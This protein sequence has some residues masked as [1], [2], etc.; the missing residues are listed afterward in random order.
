MPDESG[1]SALMDMIKKKSGDSFAA[2]LA[3]A[4]K[5]PDLWMCVHVNMAV[6]SKKTLESEGISRQSLEKIRL[7]CDKVARKMCDLGLAKL[8]GKIF[9]FDD[10]DVAALFLCAPPSGNQ[11][12]EKLRN[13]FIA[14]G[15]GA[16]FHS[17]PVKDKLANLIALSEEKIKSAYDYQSKQHAAD[18]VEGIVTI[19]GPDNAL[20]KT[21]QK[22][23]R[24]HAIGVVLIIEDDLLTREMMVA[25]LKKEYNVVQAENA[26]DAIAAY[27]ANAPNIVLLDIHLPDHSGHRVLERIKFLDPQAYAVM[28][29]ADGVVNNVLVASAHGSDGFIKKPFSKEKILEYIKKC[30][31]LGYDETTKTFA[32]SKMSEVSK[33]NQNSSAGSI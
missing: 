1:R 24:E 28:V 13:E 6:A 33:A 20:T 9:L 17:Y 19:G 16:S 4:A 12:V 14:L 3:L 10:G 15:P 22:Q 5:E 30:P 25:A 11:I 32:R 18:R 26:K 8:E 31:T 23:K 27:I 7:S 21:I 29:S 2:S